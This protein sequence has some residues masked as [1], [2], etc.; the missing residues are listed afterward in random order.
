MKRSQ[1]LLAFGLVFVIFPMATAQSNSWNAYMLRGDQSLQQGRYAEAESSYR[2]ALF[3][4]DRSD[5]R[6]PRRPLTLNNLALVYRIKG[7]Y[8]QA[9][10]LYKQALGASETVF[11]PDDPQT[12][13][14]A[15]N[16]AEL[17]RMQGRY[18]KAEP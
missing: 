3:Q 8:M 2:A 16:L 15:N 7:Q 14:I 17:Y 13:T 18:S 9:E 6:D 11:G 4:L 12:A 1:M 10:P 5:S